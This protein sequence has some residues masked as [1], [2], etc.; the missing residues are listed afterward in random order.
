[1]AK[2]KKPKRK[3]TRIGYKIL[4]QVDLAGHSKWLRNSNDPIKA[5]HQRNQLASQITAK[6]KKKRFTLVSWAGDGGLFARSSVEDIDFDS[7]VHAAGA[8][9]NEFHSWLQKITRNAGPAAKPPGLG[10]RISAHF[11]DKILLHR[12]PGYWA[13]N[14]LNTFMKYERH[15]GITGTIAVTRPLWDMLSEDLKAKFPETAERKFLLASEPGSTDTIRKIRYAPMASFIKAPSPKVTQLNEWLSMLLQNN[16]ANPPR[17]AVSPQE[18]RFGGATLLRA[19]THPKESFVI[20]IERTPPRRRWKLPAALRKTWEARRK[21]VRKGDPYPRAGLGPQNKVCPSLIKQ[22]SPEL[23]L[24]TIKCH[25]ESWSYLRAL[26]LLLKENPRFRQD[27]KRIGTDPFKPM[28]FPGLLVVHIIIRIIGPDEGPCALLCQR[29]PRRPGTHYH[30]GKWSF[31]IEE[32]MNP[33]ETV[34]QCVRR[35]LAEELLGATESEHINVSQVAIFYEEEILNLSLLAVVDVPLELKQIREYWNDYATDKAEHSLLVGFPLE[36]DL[37][38]ECARRENL[39]EHVRDQLE[40]CSDDR[41]NFN[42][43]KKWKLHPTSAFRMATA[44]WLQ[45]TR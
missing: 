22:P 10:L 31:S 14:S 21:K 18:I 23:P 20:D 12:N 9:A 17:T 24:V 34:E 30:N 16:N 40:I 8:V 44:L 45:K 28:K 3:G 33:G 15:I 26:H 37:V 11:A 42:K 38:L 1:M 35:G 32:Q 25:E 19:V 2:G 29:T 43:N 4:V 36:E 39:P 5:A 13:S 6:M 27:L 41:K 7:S